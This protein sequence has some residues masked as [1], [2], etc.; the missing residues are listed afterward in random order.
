[1]KTFQQFLTEEENLKALNFKKLS[2]KQI[3]Q[4]LRNSGEETEVI[5]TKAK[6]VKVNRSNTGL[7]FVYDC[8]VSYD[9]PWSTEEDPNLTV[10]IH[11]DEQ[12]GLIFG[13][14]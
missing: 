7:D 3:Q 10:Y 5:V 9:E 12:S 13:S 14:L 1:M 8:E 6:F 11:L 4:S 2:P